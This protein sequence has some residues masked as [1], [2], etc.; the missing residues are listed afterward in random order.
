MKI[1][2]KTDLQ[3]SK[4]A[5]Y[6]RIWRMNIGCEK[7]WEIGGKCLPSIA[8]TNESKT[9]Q[10]MNQ[11]CL[12]AA[13]KDDT[14]QLLERPPDLFLEHLVKSNI[15]I[16]KLSITENDLPGDALHIVY[17][18]TKTEEQK[19]ERAG[20]IRLGASS[21]ITAKVNSKIEAR[22]YARR[23]GLQVTEGY[24]CRTIQE[25]TKACQTMMENGI[26]KLVV[27]EPYGAS[28][29]GMFFV[30]DNQTFNYLCRRLKKHGE[31]FLLLVEKWYPVRLNFNYQM[32]IRDD[33][34]VFYIPP[35]NQII[36]N[37]VYIGGFGIG[38]NPYLSFSQK[39]HIQNAA[40]QLANELY[41]DGY[42]GMASVDGIITE[43]NQIYPVIEIN[44]RFSLSTYIAFLPYKNNIEYLSYYCN[45]NSNVDL[46]DVLSG[47]E[48]EP[49]RWET[50]KGILL[51]SFKNGVNNQY[52]GR[53]FFLMGGDEEEK[54]TYLKRI[55]EVCGVGSKL[56]TCHTD[57][58]L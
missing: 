20:G 17:G 21:N 35:K 57:A 18:I 34:A 36:V 28:G 52:S 19:I 44:G 51:Y 41:Q 42:W 56:S 6:P 3:I 25:L 49:F 39:E 38:Y 50:G 37:G 2:T 8:N 47:I 16:P 46:Q 43:E 45:V 40:Q 26:E 27:K 58:D 1:L 11:L 5:V 32:F 13:G 48:E 22:N 31:P 9:I 7:E 55:K 30:K 54:Q 12:L 24:V 15:P 53:A 29:K 23:A 14:V 10:N 33:G 4:K